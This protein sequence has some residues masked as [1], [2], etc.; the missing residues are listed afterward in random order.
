M[1]FGE[2]ASKI[3]R[4]KASNN[5]GVVVP[6]ATQHYMMLQRSLIYTAVTRGKQLV[7]VVGSRR[8]IS[9]AV[10]NASARSR[11]TWLAERIRASAEL[12]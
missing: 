12:D 4:R 11:W 10:R 1:S 8:A 2:F 5:S 9:M 7:V 3:S 6:I